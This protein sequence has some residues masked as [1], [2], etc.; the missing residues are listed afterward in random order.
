MRQFF[1]SHIKHFCDSWNVRQCSSLYDKEA[2]RK[3]QISK[4]QDLLCLF[5]KTV[6]SHKQK[7]FLRKYHPILNWKFINLYLL[8]W[9]SQN[10]KL[11]PCGECSDQPRTFCNKL[12]YHSHTS[13]TTREGAADMIN[14][15]IEWEEGGISSQ[16]TDQGGQHYHLYWDTDMSYWPSLQCLLWYSS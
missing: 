5:L 2:D 10:Y 6:L 4:Y 14:D 11:E 16:H 15:A 7:V 3:F 13:Y 1:L 12:L 8:Y 9:T